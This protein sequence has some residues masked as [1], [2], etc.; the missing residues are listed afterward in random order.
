MYTESRLQ[1]IRLQRVPRYS[2]QI[3][4]ARLCINIID[5]NVK[6]F[7]YN[8]HPLTMSSIF[9]SFYSLLAG[10]SVYPSVEPNNVYYEQNYFVVS[11]TEL[12]TINGVVY[13]SPTLNN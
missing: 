8:E 9:A 2:E 5:F 12:G 7:G 4:L 13:F 10:P 3:S 11:L 6:K 1:R